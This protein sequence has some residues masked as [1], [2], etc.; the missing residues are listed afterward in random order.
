MERIHIQP[1]NFCICILKSRVLI[2]VN[3]ILSVG[4]MTLGREYSDVKI[5]S[6]FIIIVH[7]R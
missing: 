6:K 5:S 4:I 2:Y 3:E 1:V 7:R